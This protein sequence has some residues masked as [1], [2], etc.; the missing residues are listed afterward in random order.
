MLALRKNVYMVKG[1]VNAAI[2]DFNK[3][4]LYSINEDAKKLLESVLWK[5]DIKL[6]CEEDKYLKE[7]VENE[8]LTTEDIPV[9][10][11]EELKVKPIIDFVWIELTTA[12]NLKCVHCYDESTCKRSEFMDFKDFCSIIDQILELG[13]K[14]I[15]LIGGEPFFLGDKL[16]KYI[17]Y[18]KDKFEF[19]EIYTNG[20]LVEEK[21]FKYLSENNIRMALS[22]YSYNENEHDKVTQIKGSWEKTNQTIAKLKD[23]NITYR[24]RNVM[25]KDIHIGQNNTELYTLSYKRDIVRMVGRANESLLS[26]DLLNKK[27]ITKNTF[28]SKLDKKFISRLISGHNCFSR[29]LYFGADLNVYPCVMER[30]IKHGSL[31]NNK[32]KDILDNNIFNI[33]KD[34]IEE[35]KECE[36][37]Y[38]CFDCRPDSLGKS[39][40]KKP[41]YCSYIPE[42]GEW[43]NIKS[44]KDC[45]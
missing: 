29:R 41:W 22:V 15:Q 10:T 23:Y 43:K 39:I 7:L 6:N 17:D 9:H 45:E 25:M 13:I 36:F 35:C 5:S 38:C 26:E 24:V 44:L 19:I 33:T 31:K 18:V 30:R 16:K 42:K 32:L 2:Y 20:T 28:R 11:I 37:R 40:L 1:A 3:N 4:Y 14:K 27:L 8:V 34:S 21:W 12:C